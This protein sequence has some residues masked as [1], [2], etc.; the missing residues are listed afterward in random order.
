VYQESVQVPPG[1]V[2]VLK[3]NKHD[4]LLHK[5]PFNLLRHKTTKHVVLW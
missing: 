5:H 2:N 3:G 4:K 1:M